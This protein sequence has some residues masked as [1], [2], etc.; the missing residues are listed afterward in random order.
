MKSSA[1]LV[2]IVVKLASGMEGRKNYFSGRPSVGWM[3]INGNT[4]SVVDNGYALI[5]MYR[6]VDLSAESGHSF[7][8]GVVYNFVDKVVKSPGTSI[9]NIHSRSS[10][11]SLKTFKNLYVIC[12]VKTGGWCHLKISFLLKFFQIS[13][14]FCAKGAISFSEGLGLESSGKERAVFKI[15]CSFVF[16]PYKGDNS[17]YGYDTFSFKGNEQVRRPPIFIMYITFIL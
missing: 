5:W 8:Y 4:P 6:H 7:I 15:Y 12:S 1:Y 2:N 10:A 16:F 11:Y 13:P 17:V 9:S 3:G 14:C